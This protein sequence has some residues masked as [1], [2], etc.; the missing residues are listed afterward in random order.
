MWEHVDMMVVVCAAMCC[1]LGIITKLE[2]GDSDPGYN[3][4]KLVL[5]VLTTTHPV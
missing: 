1:H 2:D 4:S 3:D 5:V